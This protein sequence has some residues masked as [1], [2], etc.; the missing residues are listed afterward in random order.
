M[1]W[2]A[3][4]SAILRPVAYE[5]VKKIAGQRLVEQGRARPAAC[6]SRA[7]RRRAARP[8]PCISSPI[9]SP[10]RVANSDGLYSTALPVSSAGTN[11]FEPTNYG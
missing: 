11:T 9:A 5:P 7:G 6:P 10:V 2:R 4:A 1:S 3:A 8:P